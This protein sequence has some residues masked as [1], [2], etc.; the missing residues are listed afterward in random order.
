MPHFDACLSWNW[1]YDAD[2]V[3]SFEVAC[4]DDGVH[5]RNAFADFVAVAFDEAS[6]DDELS[7]LPVCFELRHFKD[8]VDGLL[9]G[10]VDEAAGVDDEDFGLL[11]TRGQA[12]A[13]AI[14]EAHH[15]LGVDQVF[16]AA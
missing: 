2:F 3:H 14:E 7:G 1:E 16:G 13:T 15:D 8:G 12:R 10:G 4:A 6:S 9:L 11:G 5:F